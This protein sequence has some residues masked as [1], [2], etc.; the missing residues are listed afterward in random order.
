ML[1]TIFQK[2]KN[3]RLLIEQASAICSKWGLHVAVGRGR[4]D[5]KHKQLVVMLLARRLYLYRRCGSSK[6]KWLSAQRPSPDLPACTHAWICFIAIWSYWA[7]QRRLARRRRTA[8]ILL[9]DWTFSSPPPDICL[10]EPYPKAVFRA[11]ELNWT[12]LQP[13]SQ[14]TSWRRRAL[15]IT[16][17]V[18]GSTWSMSVQ[19]S[20]P[21][22]NKV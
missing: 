19:F 22:V 13:C 16:R 4:E 7:T 18:T 3:L 21:A 1:P 17:R 12:E 10:F 11:D 5:E 14:S 9:D 8:N 6:C 20:S 2:V 15:P